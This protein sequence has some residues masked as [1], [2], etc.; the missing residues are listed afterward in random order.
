[1]FALFRQD[2]RFMRTP[3]EA[4]FIPAPENS[5]R[6][7]VAYMGWPSASSGIGLTSRIR[8]VCLRDL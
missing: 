3:E 2:V 1:M 5:A 4:N 8:D 6:F 7:T